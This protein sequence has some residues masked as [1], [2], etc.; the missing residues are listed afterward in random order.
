MRESRT[1][2]S[3]RGARGNSRPYRDE[4]ICG[5]FMFAGIPAY[6]CAHA[7]YM[8]QGRRY[9]RRHVPGRMVVWPA[10]LALAGTSRS[11]RGRFAAL[12]LR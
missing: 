1:Y 7:G 8:L 2:G 5:F 11:E 4:A 3:V 9:N 6:R 12:L 10:G